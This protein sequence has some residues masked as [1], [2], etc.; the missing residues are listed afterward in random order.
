MLERGKLHT[1]GG[2][3]VIYVQHHEPSDPKQH[4]NWLPAPKEGFCFTVRFYGPYTP[5]IDGSYD[6]PCIVW[7]DRIGMDST[8]G[9]ERFKAQRFQGKKDQNRCCVNPVPTFFTAG[10]N[11]DMDVVPSLMVIAV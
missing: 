3:L 1:E 5:L 2:K 11:F 9:C 10:Q 4:Q 6:V 7:V 8:S